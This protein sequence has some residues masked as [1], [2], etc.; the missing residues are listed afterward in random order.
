[1]DTIKIERKKTKLIAHRGLSGIERENTAAAF[2]AAG[3]RGYDGIETDIHHTADG[4]YILFH[5]NHTARLNETDLTIEKSKFDDLRAIR[6]YDHFNKKRGDLCLPTPEEYLRICRTYEK[7]AVLELKC[8][9]QEQEIAEILKMVHNEYDLKQMVFISF[10]WENLLLVRKQEKKAHLQFLTSDAVDSLDLAA[11]RANRIGL[12]IYYPKLNRDHIAQLHK[13]GIEVNC[14][15]VDDK[16]DA[17]RLI[18]WGVDYI[19]TNIL[20]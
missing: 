13:Q 14:W 1:M 19:T 9:F 10:I 15:T 20:E 18:K 3:N 2:V 4:K 12:D 8:R 5:D 17:A 16:K 11:M 7:T 6:L